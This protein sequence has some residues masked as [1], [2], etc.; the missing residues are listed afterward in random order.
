MADP[1]A[2]TTVPPGG[3][4]RLPDPL[5][6][7]DPPEQKSPGSLH[8]RQ[9]AS[10]LTVKLDALFPGPWAVVA[11]PFPVGTTADNCYD[12]FMRIGVMRGTPPYHS[13]VT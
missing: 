7:V 1:I 5:A 6:L 2:A 12:R 4:F 11:E 9:S 13:I 3:V 10:G 8:Y